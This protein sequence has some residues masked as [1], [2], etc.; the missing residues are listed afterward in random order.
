MVLTRGAGST[1]TISIYSRACV[2]EVFPFLL[3]Y[4]HFFFWFLQLQ[5][6]YLHILS[7]D[8][9]GDLAAET[10]GL[11]FHGT[12]DLVLQAVLT[13]LP[14]EELSRAAGLASGVCSEKGRAG[15]EDGVCGVLAELL[16]VGGLVEALVDGGLGD[17]L[18]DLAK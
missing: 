17:A 9:G 7:L 12:W 18:R 1:I 5:D 4:V 13:W 16:E 14:S 8:L 3:A 15:G 6:T 2:R 11:L 10:I